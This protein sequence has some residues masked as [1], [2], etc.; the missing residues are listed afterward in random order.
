MPI[1]TKY[2]LALSKRQ[3]GKE[4]KC[5]NTK[6]TNDSHDGL[7]GVFKKDMAEVVSSLR[8]SLKWSLENTHK[9]RALLAR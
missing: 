8:S 4:I 9:H 3:E 5:S 2:I 7:E 1:S 6:K